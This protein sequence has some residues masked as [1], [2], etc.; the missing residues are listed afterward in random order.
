MADFVSG[1]TASSLLVTCTD[2]MGAVINLN[3]CSVNLHWQQATGTIADKT[4]TIIS[5]VDGVC[6]YKFL[7]GELFAPGMAF[8]IEITDA[9]GFKLSNINLITA[10]VR[11]HLV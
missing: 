10:N 8:E 1:D 9:S 6:S 2:D 11:A 3:G 7:T 5:A 4:M